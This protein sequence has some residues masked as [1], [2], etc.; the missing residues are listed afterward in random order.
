MSENC[1][2]C[3]IVSGEIKACKIDEDDKSIVFLDTSPVFHGHCLISPK[4]HFET[5]MDV[6]VARLEP[7]FSKAQLV[8]RAVEKGLGSDGS[9]I[10]IN[11]RVSQTVP[12][13]HVHVI[14]RKRK[15][16]MKGFFWPRHKYRDEAHM[17]ETRQA[18]QSAMAALKA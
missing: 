12:H 13:L 1:V 8:A 15:D 3:K 11:N 14:P 18:L 5:L 4:E 6:P 10:A 16:G 9:F 7:L 2:F 17:E